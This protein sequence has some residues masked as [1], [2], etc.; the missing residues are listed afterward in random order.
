M[1][2]KGY[3]FFGIF[4]GMLVSGGTF[5]GLKA[6]SE[7]AGSLA[8]QLP[9]LSALLVLLNIVITQSGKRKR[10]LSR[11]PSYGSVHSAAFTM[12]LL[13]GVILPFVPM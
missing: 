6:G 11:H 4:V 9:F 10:V 3:Y 5:L 1:S 12:L 8:T 7:V 13:L 2:V